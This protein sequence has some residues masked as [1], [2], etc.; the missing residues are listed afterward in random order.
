[1]WCRAYGDGRVLYNALGHRDDV[2][3]AETFKKVIVDNIKWVRGD[4]PLMADPNY[5]AVVPKTIK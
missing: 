3:N 5:E 4:G 2:W 1:M